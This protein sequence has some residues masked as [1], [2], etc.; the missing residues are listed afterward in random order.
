MTIKVGIN[1]F[2]RI[3]RNILRAPLRERGPAPTRSGL[4]P[5]TTSAMPRPMHISPATTPRTGAS[6]ARSRSTADTLVVN[7]DRIAVL[8]ERDPAKLPWGELGVDVVHEC[9]GL[10]ASKDQ[11]RQAP[12]RRREEGHHLRPRRR[13]R[14]RD[15][16]LR[17]EPPVALGVAHRHLQCVVHHPTASRRSRRPS[18]D[19]VGIE[20][21]LMTTNPCLHQ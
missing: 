3:G 6:R 10:F 13:R 8:A 14:G 9:T 1:G 19:R 2:G 21:G 5:S 18:T 7:G 16:G 11:G 20:Q 4:S 17:S 15:G 12:R